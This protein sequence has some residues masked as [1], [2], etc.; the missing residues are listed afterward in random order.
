MCRSSAAHEE[1]STDKRRR[2]VTKVYLSRDGG[3][4]VEE[5]GRVNTA[6]SD[7]R[8][9][10]IARLFFPQLAADNLGT[11]YRDRLYY[12]WEDGGEE[13]RILFSPWY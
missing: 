1:R 2:P 3:Q 5:V 4:T 8:L 13:A 7:P 9:I 11:T 10:T 6:W 12:V